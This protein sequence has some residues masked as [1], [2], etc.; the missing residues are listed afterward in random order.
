MIPEGA[1]VR[2]VRGPARGKRWIANS[3]TPGFW[4]GYWELANQ[5][6]FAAQ[7][8][9]GNVVYDVGAHVG[10]YTLLSSSAVRARGSGLCL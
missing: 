1:V 9:P 6:R 7:L 10:L 3:S 5:R 2:V 4:L 8:R